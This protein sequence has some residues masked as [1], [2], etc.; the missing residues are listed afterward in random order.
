MAVLIGIQEPHTNK[1]GVTYLPDRYLIYD[2]SGRDGTA[3]A[4]IFASSNLN[5]T[6]VPS[7]TSRDMATGLWKTGENSI[8]QIMVVSLYLDGTYQR[9]IPEKL[10]NITDYC[11]R[12]NLELL[13]LSDVNAHSCLWG[14]TSTNRRGED[15]ED[16][17]FENNLV[18]LNEGTVERNYTYYRSNS[19]SKLYRSNSFNVILVAIILLVFS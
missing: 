7:Y 9:T 14:E 13:I 19:R 2:R 11:R 8:P 12:K 3:R 18:V 6:P 10:Q 17:L 1:K 15:V 4:A 16:F 5:V